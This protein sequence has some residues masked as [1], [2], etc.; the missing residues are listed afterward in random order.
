MIDHLTRFSTSCVIKIKHKEILVKKIF[1]IPI[2]IFGFLVDNKGEFN[3]QE[4]ISLC[5]NV[6]IHICTTAAEAPWS[7][8]LVGRHKTIVDVKCVL[9]LALEYVTAANNSLKKNQWI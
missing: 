7:N 8:G 5:K 1:Q 6:N 9:E 3:N 2:S 4:F